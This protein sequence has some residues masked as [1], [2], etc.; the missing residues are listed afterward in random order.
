[1]LQSS[2]TCQNQRHPKKSLDFHSHARPSLRLHEKKSCNRDDRDSSVTVPPSQKETKIGGPGPVGPARRH[3]HSDC[4][5]HGRQAQAT[6]TVTRDRGRH[7]L[8]G[9]PPAGT[10]GTVLAA[11]H[12]CSISWGEM[13]Q[14]GF[15]SHIWQHS[16]ALLTI[17]YRVRSASKYGAM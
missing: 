8:R 11:S 14:Q 10:T 16:P 7:V 12:R 13:E 1:V 17:A 6:A 9:Y 15:L 5:G 2:A 3:G 4:H